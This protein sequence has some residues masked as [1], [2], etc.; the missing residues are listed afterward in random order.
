MSIDDNDKYIVVNNVNV[1]VGANDD[2]L[3][4]SEPP[5]RSEELPEPPFRS[6]DRAVGLSV[7]YASYWF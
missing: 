4:P 6:D 1:L 5:Y 3:S 2:Y 7:S